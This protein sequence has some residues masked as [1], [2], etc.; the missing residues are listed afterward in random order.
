MPDPNDIPDVLGLIEGE[1]LDAMR[2]SRLRVVSR[3]ANAPGLT[4]GE[5]RVVRQ[6]LLEPGT[7]ELLLAATVTGPACEQE[8]G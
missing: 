8:R 3:L 2:R 4:M 1:A 5:R 6:R 7:V